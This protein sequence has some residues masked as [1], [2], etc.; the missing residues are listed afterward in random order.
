MLKYFKY[1][2]IVETTACSRNI[3]IYKFNYEQESITFYLT[4]ISS[5]I[6]EGTIVEVNHLT[7]ATKF[8][9]FGSCG[10]LDKK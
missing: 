8:I 6:A 5:A 9:M 7:R 10:S 4:P 1:E 3:P 2:K